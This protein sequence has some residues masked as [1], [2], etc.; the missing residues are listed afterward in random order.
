MDQNNEKLFSTFPP[1]TKA[2]WEERIMADLKGADYQKKLVWKTSEGFDVKPYYRDEDTQGIG[3]LNVLPGEFPFVRGNNTRSNDW[4]IRQDIETDDETES[5][6][7]AVDAIKRGATGIGMVAADLE[8]EQDVENLLK[9]INPAEVAIHFGA[10]PSYPELLRNVAAFAKAHKLPVEKMKGSF[11]FD[12]ISYLLLNGDFWKSE[13]SDLGQVATMIKLGK[14]NLPA[15]KMVNVNGHYFNSAGAT[16]AEELGFSLASGNEYLAQATAAGLSVDDAAQRMMFS[17]GIGSNYFM[18]IARLRAARML[19]AK[20]VEQYKPASDAS[21]Q[22]YI[23]STTSAWNK[24][25]FDPYVNLL[26][27]T[28]E[29]MSAVIGGTQSLSILPFDTFY[30]DPD[31]FSTRLARN[32]QIILKEEVYLDKVV[33]PSA[34]SYYIENLTQLIAEAAW[35][36]FL[37]VEEK[38]GMVEAVKAGFVQEIIEKSAAQR[39]EDIANRRLIQLGTNQY[40]NLNEEMLGQIHFAEEDEELEEEI[41]AD[42][43]MEI[44]EEDEDEAPSTYKKLVLFGGSDAFD[45]LRLATEQFVE[46]GNKKPAVFLFNIGNLAM[47]K[48]RA[49]FTTNFFGCAGY[50]ILDNSGFQTVDEGVE[51]AKAS[52]AEIVVICS[53]DDEYATLGAEI[54]TKLKAANKEIILVVA[55]YPKEILDTLKQA[56][57]EEFIHVRSNLLQTL[58]SFQEKLGIF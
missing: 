45:Q 19:W 23:H 2:E 14:E 33:D 30:K 8:T 52:N 4:E 16:I 38:G 20:I 35:K 32:Q 27:S 15:M 22:M 42:E 51:A 11:D 25:L 53:S 50:E 40:P 44:D 58:E 55:G 13:K 43:D 18:E 57:V 1:V 39:L 28:T 17:F 21:M 54:A 6:R 56:G 24:T 5:N 47:R 7:L 36:V 12:P 49:M 29:A 31:E 37:Q 10:A 46:E 3:T 41:Y 26:R 34:G 48:A 9:G